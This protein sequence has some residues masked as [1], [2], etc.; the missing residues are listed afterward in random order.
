[1]C[2]LSI[3]TINLNNGAGLRK[4]IESLVKQAFNDIEYIII[5][6][7]STDDS[8]E[9]IKE[10]GEKITYWVSESDKGIY[11]AMNKGILKS[12][13]KYLHFLNS[14]DWLADNDVYK[15]I[16]TKEPD[17][18]IIYGNLIKVYPTGKMVLDKG[19][20]GNNITFLSMYLGNLNHQSSFIRK[21]LFDHYGLYDE[22]YKILS[23]WKL[24]LQSMGLNEA[25]VIYKD[26]NIAYFDMSGIC[27]TQMDTRKMEKQEIL[28]ELIPAPILSDY[29]NFG[30]D[31]FWIDF[32]KKHKITSK[33]FRLSQKVLIRFSRVLDKL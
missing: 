17:C 20:E 30:I 12:K 11:N 22:K 32:I 3:I 5:D 28:K 6:G 23:D 21:E 27:N 10:Y 16:F 7:G 1:M 9:V 13:G 26:R 15:D 8:V 29:E 24:F 31:I 4:T 19:I 25:R 18:D 14:G 2:K 33:I